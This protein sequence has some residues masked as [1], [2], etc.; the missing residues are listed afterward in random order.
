MK[1][2]SARKYSHVM[3]HKTN[4]LASAQADFLTATV[5]ELQDI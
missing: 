2:T 4:T 1:K 3:L 5:F